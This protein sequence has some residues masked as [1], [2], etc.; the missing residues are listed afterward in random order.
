[1]QT[2]GF[3]ATL[4]ILTLSARLGIYLRLCR[5]KSHCPCCGA[6][7]YW[8]TRVKGLC[9]AVHF[10]HD[11]HFSWGHIKYQN[12]HFIFAGT[13]YS[14][15]QRNECILMDS[16][17]F[18]ILFLIRTVTKFFSSSWQKT[19]LYMY[20]ASSSQRQHFEGW[21]QDCS[22]SDG[23]FSQYLISSPWR[24]YEDYNIS[25]CKQWKFRCHCS[26]EQW[27]LNLHCLQRGQSYP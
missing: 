12:I 25:F 27:H 23:C 8:C 1:M 26:Y 4:F 22:K 21:S 5:L 18:I 15:L 19:V 24:R 9:F 17:W 14:I 10:W 2:D 11:E 20:K 13:C 3:I 6:S 7:D 16:E